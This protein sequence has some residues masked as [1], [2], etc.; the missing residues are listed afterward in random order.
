[1]D[2]LELAWQTY[3]F[4]TEMATEFEDKHTNLIER[5]RNF[6]IKNLNPSQSQKK[7]LLNRL[8]KSFN[9]ILNTYVKQMDAITDLIDLY[10]SGIEIPEERKVENQS[11]YSLL[12]VT[13]TLS[14]EMK[15]HR[16]EINEILR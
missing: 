4:H 13:A 8:N 15:I 9:R 12:N 1:M 2:N 3:D 5:Y 14:K 11:F 6:I 7:W 10:N 16:K